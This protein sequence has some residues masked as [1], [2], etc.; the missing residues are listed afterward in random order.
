MTLF[1]NTIYVLPLGYEA[2]LQTHRKQEV[3]LQFCIW[4]R[5]D[6]RIM[7]INNWAK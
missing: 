7:K 6:L 1:S 3:Q 5:Q 2:K 4:G